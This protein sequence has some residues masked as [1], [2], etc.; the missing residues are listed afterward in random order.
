MFKG[1]CSTS[2]YFY[3]FA[4][5]TIEQHLDALGTAGTELEGNAHIAR[6]LALR[7]NTV[8]KDTESGCVSK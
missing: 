2:S 3:L 7:A 1:S 6:G 5:K 8:G 4:F